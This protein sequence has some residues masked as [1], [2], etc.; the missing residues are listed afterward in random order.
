MKSTNLSFAILV[1]LLFFGAGCSSAPEPTSPAPTPPTTTPPAE[2]PP[3]AP[4]VLDE[5]FVVSTPA[6]EGIDQ[7]AFDKLV[8]KAKSEH[9]EAVVILRNGKLV[10]K[11]YFGT[12]DEPIIAMSASKSFTSLAY[13]FLLADGKLA[14][15]DETVGKRFPAFASDERKAKV[16]YRHLLT[17]TAG[18]DPMRADLSKSDIY[19]TG[20]AAK[21]IFEPGTSWQYSNGGIDMLAA[22]AGQLAGKP[23][24]EYLNE[25]LFRPMGIADVEWMTDKKGVPLGA[26][27]M[28]IRPLDM[29]KVGQMLLDGGQ[30]QGKQ[31]VDKAW[32]DQSFAQSNTIE[33]LYGLLWW[34]DADVVSVGLTNEVISQWRVAGYA[35]ESASKAATLVGKKYANYTKLRNA[36]QGVLGLTEMSDLNTLISTG[37]HVPFFRNLEIGPV[38]GANAAGWL[39]QFL[40]VDPDKKLVGVRMRRKRSTDDAVV[41]EV[42]GFNTFPSVVATLV[43]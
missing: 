31:V 14:S 20:I 19:A 42:D 37:N 6:A 15:V 28:A 33:P 30:W 22:L 17:Q 11:D 26:G 36:L 38:R 43:R 40:V 9:S 24:N 7:A 8:A 16:T 34:R 25:R 41:G 4:A 18:L 10:Y 12:A 39:G 27:E 21:C 13:G 29:A 35:E 5:G 32:I 1:G 23:M 2:T 3:P